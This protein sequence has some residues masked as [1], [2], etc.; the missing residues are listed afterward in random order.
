MIG[1]RGIAATFAAG[2]I[3]AVCGTASQP[4]AATGLAYVGTLHIGCFGCGTFG[5]GG[6]SGAIT[7]TVGPAT[8]T[9]TVNESPALCP[10][11]GDGF[12]VVNGA[13]NGTL[14]WVRVGAVWHTTFNGL[15][16]DGVFLITSPVG[17]PCGVPV[18][19]AVAGHL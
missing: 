1:R 15:P 2:L 14:T 5:P 19:V 10:L 11:V 12:G 17:N 16:G 6:N 8:L 9:F 4:A 7:T 18:D 3:A 13:I